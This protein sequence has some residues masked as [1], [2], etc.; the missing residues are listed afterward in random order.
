[1]L[2]ESKKE[3][4]IRAIGDGSDWPKITGDPRVNHAVDVEVCGVGQPW[5]ELG[6]KTRKAYI[7]EAKAF[8]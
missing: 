4:V 8:H 6:D 5:E 3:M 7:E 2:N 1:M